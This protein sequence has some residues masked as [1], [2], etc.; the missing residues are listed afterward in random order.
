MALINGTIQPG[1]GFVPATWAITQTY[2]EW[3][4]RIDL[5]TDY[6]VEGNAAVG[7]EW[8]RVAVAATGS[9]AYL[10]GMPYIAR[11]QGLGQVTTIGRASMWGTGVAARI[12]V[13]F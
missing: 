3:R 12:S 2:E 7:Y 10:D 1:A 5:Q 8:N 13:A 6:I 4:A 9:F 11:T